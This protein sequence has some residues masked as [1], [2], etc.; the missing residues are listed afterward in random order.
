MRETLHDAGVS[1]QPKPQKGDR[2]VEVLRVV[3][4]IEGLSYLLLVFVAMPLKYGLDEPL[5]VRVVG[6]GHGWLFVAFVAALAWAT[7]GRRWGVGRAALLFGL[8]LLPFGFLVIDRKL[9][10]ATSR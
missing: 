3:S 5:A 7:V 9:R 10:R 6:A 1:T 8:S 2:A 4:A